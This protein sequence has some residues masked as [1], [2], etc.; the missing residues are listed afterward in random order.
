MK[1]LLPLNHPV[2]RLLRSASAARYDAY[3]YGGREKSDGYKPAP[4]TL[5]RVKFLE[6]G[7]TSERTSSD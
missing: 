2:L 6:T 1:R 7:E 5:P 3:G 4:I